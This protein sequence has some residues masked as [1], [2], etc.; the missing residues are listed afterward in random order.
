[1]SRPFKTTR[2]GASNSSGS[3]VP[4]WWPSMS[5]RST[6]PG[7]RGRSPTAGVTGGERFRSLCSHHHRNSGGFSSAGSAFASA[8][9]GDRIGDFPSRRDRQ[10]PPNPAQ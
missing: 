5:R 3:D 9:G 2:M 6:G 10:A 8:R 4:P 7:P 1:M